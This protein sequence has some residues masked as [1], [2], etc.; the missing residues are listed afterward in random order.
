MKKNQSVS[1]GKSI[2]FGIEEFVKIHNKMYNYLYRYTKYCRQL[3]IRR[4]L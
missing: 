2:K 4:D 3:H 1:R